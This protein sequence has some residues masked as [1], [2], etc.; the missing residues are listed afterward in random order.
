MNEELYTP[1]QV[2]MLFGVTTKTI[3]NW[4]KEGRFKFK[5]TPTGYSR[6]FKQEIDGLLS[7]NK[8]G[9][10]RICYCRVSSSGQK[11]DLERQVQ[12]FRLKYPTH[13]IIRDIGSGLNFK[14]KGFNSLVERIYRGNVEEVVVTHRDRLCRFGTEFIEQILSLSG[15]KLVVLDDSKTSPQQE[16]VEDL[17]SIVTVFSSRLSGIKTIKKCIEESKDF[18]FHTKTESYGGREVKNDDEPTKV[19]H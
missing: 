18:K 1:K 13:T 15:G 19:V 12:F 8:S 14:R 5:K 16:L 9:K 4:Q 10:E 17:L 6:F 11:E 7:G 3:S 2:A